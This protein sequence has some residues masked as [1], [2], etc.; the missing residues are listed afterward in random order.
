MKLKLLISTGIITLFGV[1]ILTSCQKREQIK[2]NETEQALYE[3][4]A[5]E[6]EAFDKDFAEKLPP[7]TRFSWKK[8]WSKVKGG[9][10]VVCSD[11]VGAIEGTNLGAKIDAKTGKTSYTISISIASAVTA[12]KAKAMQ[13]FGT[14]S[15][16]QKSPNSNTKLLTS[17]E[18]GS[19]VGEIHNLVMDDL[20]NEYD[21]KGIQ[22]VSDEQL[23]KDILRLTKKYLKEDIP[24]YDPSILR[25]I[26][27]NT[28]KIKQ[29]FTS[30]DDQ[31]T[32]KCLRNIESE[33][34]AEI[35]F[36]ADYL[37]KIQSLESIQDR[38]A[39]A[40]GYSKVVI[41][42]RLPQPA[43]NVILN[44]TS[45]AANSLLLWERNP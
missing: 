11:I 33:S 37:M 19:I 39:Y 15:E 22:D 40:T 31:E 10:K 9:F 26:I 4:F 14:N 13:E 28:N 23:L 38:K 24:E 43:K 20:F 44:G 30:L 25:Q 29:T 8:L 41:K 18:T 21:K 5:L 1:L 3:E 2:Q 42:S 27:S 6:I 45:T 34:K 17:E 12:S 35:K 36:I 32:I 16:K 7:Q